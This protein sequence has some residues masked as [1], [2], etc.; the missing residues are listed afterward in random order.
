MS[1][2]RGKYGLRVL[3]INSYYSNRMF[4]KNLYDIQVERGLD[5]NVYTPVPFS[6][7]E[8][9]DFGSYTTIK[10][11]HR[12]YDRFLFHLKHHKIYKDIVKEYVVKDFSIVH[13]HSLF[14]NGYIAM[15]LKKNFGI[16]YIVAVR[17][18]DL[19]IFFKRMVHLRKLGLK[20]LKYADRIIFLS[21][22]YRDKVIKK[23]IPKEHRGE[24]LNKAS[25]IP[26]GID[27]FW[28]ENVGVEKNLSEDNELKLLYVGNVNKNKN[29]LATI[30]AIE[31]LKKQGNIVKYTVVGKMEDESILKVVK[32][33]PYVKY[34]SPI[35]KEELINV[36]RGSDIFVMP[37]IYET[38]GLVYAEAISQGLPVIYARGQGF[39]TQFAEGQVGYSVDCFNPGEIADKI[40]CVKNS[41]QELT[42]NCINLHSK[43]DWRLLEREYNKIYRGCLM[44][45]I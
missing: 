21:K 42:K 23:Y 25:V 13:A 39:D 3:H 20:I 7:K 2:I 28:I 22:A 17:S 35:Q 11:N 27:K 4:Y 34:T 38:F 33:L 1:F 30:K 9:G 43:F 26:N 31:I 45:S 37:S 15:R 32:N 19:N 5:I 40:I 24:F 8:S 29:V 12:K 41:Y 36:Y 18:T 44:A 14:S 16:P 10:P 6:Y